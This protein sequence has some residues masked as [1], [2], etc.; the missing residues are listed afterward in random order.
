MT[1]GSGILHQEMPK[2]DARGRMHGFQ[3]WAN[4]P[5]HLKM[6]KPRYQDVTASDIPLVVDD[7]GTSVRIVVGS[8]W[9]KTA[10][11]TALRQSRS[12]S[13]SRCLPANSSGSRLIRADR[14]SPTS[15]RARRA[16]GMQ[17]SRLES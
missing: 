3:L 2:G 13:T 10:P 17:R 1:A 14:R 8:F 15:L 4:L 7:D 12:T 16:S 5:S 9:G 11:S 6:T